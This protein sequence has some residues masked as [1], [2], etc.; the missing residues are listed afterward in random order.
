MSQ[1]RNQRR[2][3]R[4]A[5]HLWSRQWRRS[6]RRSR[7][8]KKRRAEQAHN[9]H[10]Q[11]QAQAVN[12]AAIQQMQVAFVQVGKAFGNT[13]MQARFTVNTFEPVLEAIPDGAPPDVAG[14]LYGYRIW[15]I[16]NVFKWAYPDRKWGITTTDSANLPVPIERGLKLSSIGVQHH[17]EGKIEHAHCESWTPPGSWVAHHG[18]SPSPGCGCGLW[19]VYHP[20]HLPVPTQVLFS[21][22]QGR[23][24]SSMG[25]PYTGA[26]VVLGKVRAWGD[27]IEADR[28]FKAEFMEVMWLTPITAE[29]E[30][31]GEGVAESYEVE[32]HP[33]WDVPTLPNPLIDEVSR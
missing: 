22:A 8:D 12:L 33:K 20:L 1:L 3:R 15:R 21:A 23:P 17:W 29:G 4:R 10:L 6:Q 32:W 26:A 13:M 24:Q 27:I 19:A 7:R 16:E 5:I 14:Y 31:V 9:F 30:R 11:M 2:A 18:K 25:W 28:G